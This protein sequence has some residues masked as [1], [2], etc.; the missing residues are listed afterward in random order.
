MSHDCPEC[1][2]TLASLDDLHDHVNDEHDL[3]D[4]A[5][6]HGV[7]DGGLSIGPLRINWGGWR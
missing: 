1:S 6:E 4:R 2:E 5:L 3:V 7:D